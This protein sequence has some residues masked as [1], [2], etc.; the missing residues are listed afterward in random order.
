MPVAEENLDGRKYTVLMVAEKPSIAK[1]IAEAL[2]GK[3][4][5]TY[6]TGACKFCKIFEFYG[7]IFGKNAF[8]KVTS[9]IGH[10]YTTD[11]PQEFQD[12]RKVDPIKLFEA[13][14][15]KKET[16]PD[17]KIVEH[18]QQES[19]GSSYLVLWLDNDKEGENICFEVL[20]LTKQNLMKEDFQQVYRAKFS[21][22]TATEI[23][24]AFKSLSQGPNLNHSIAVDARQIIDLKVG[25]SF[26]RF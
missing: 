23:Q 4:G 2:S 21:S 16:N 6:R 8:F 24:Q 20:S 22:I 5:F 3:G 1:A 12:W 13:Q 7:Q 15:M 17:S 18:L 14:T 11:F 19:L 26:S 10:I 25:V 9:V